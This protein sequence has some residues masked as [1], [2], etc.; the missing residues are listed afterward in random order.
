[1]ASEMYFYQKGEVDRL[2]VCTPSVK[3]TYHPSQN[4]TCALK[5]TYKY[6][7]FTQNWWCP[8]HVYFPTHLIVLF[9]FIDNSDNI[10]FLECFNNKMSEI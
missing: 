9:L 1:M 8:K 3:Q 5:D 7:V 4:C 2:V 6:T 10:L